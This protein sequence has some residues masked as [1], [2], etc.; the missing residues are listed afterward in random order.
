MT[1]RRKP[2]KPGKPLA[3]MSAKR[4]KE[5]EDAGVFPTSTF[6]RAPKMAL[7]KRQRDT[8]PVRSVRD[9]IAERSGGICEMACFLAAVHVHHRRPRRIGGSSAPDTNSASNLLKLCM[10]HHEAIE[11]NRS[12]A[13]E[14]GLILSANAD[15]A[16]IPVRGT[17]YDAGP[18]WLLQDGFWLPFAEA[19]A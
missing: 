19:C 3:A 9:L 16:R 6:K 5:Y 11:A 4:R 18:V 7:P 17:R 10:F 2:L 12:W 14:W 13:Y 8:G 15:P 1:L